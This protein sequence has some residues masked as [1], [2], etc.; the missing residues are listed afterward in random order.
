MHHSVKNFIE[1]NIEYIEQ[2]S[3]DHVWDSWFHTGEDYFLPQFISILISTECATEEELLESRR[4]TLR[5]EICQPFINKKVRTKIKFFDVL[6][7]LYSTLYLDIDDV[8]FIF[9]DVAC[10]MGYHRSGE[11]WICD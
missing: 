2:R 4:K 3:W 10:S 11:T 8:M 1:S 9:N 6:L 7:L 5:Y